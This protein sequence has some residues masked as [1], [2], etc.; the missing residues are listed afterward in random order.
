MTDKIGVARYSRRSDYTALG[1]FLKGNS[2]NGGT[3]Y[4]TLEPK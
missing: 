4:P 2:R 1:Y 3:Y